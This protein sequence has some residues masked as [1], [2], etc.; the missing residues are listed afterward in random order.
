MFRFAEAIVVFGAIV[1]L[2][3]SGFNLKWLE[4]RMASLAV[5]SY[6]SGYISIGGFQRELEKPAKRK[7]R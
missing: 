2:G 6:K 3:V 4:G 7:G 5:K 1:A